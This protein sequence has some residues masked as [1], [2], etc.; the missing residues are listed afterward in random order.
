MPLFSKICTCRLKCQVHV[1]DV[2]GLGLSDDVDPLV[3]LL[4]ALS[5]HEQ[6]SPGASLMRA[7]GLLMPGEYA[8]DEINPDFSHMKLPVYILWRGGDGPIFDFGVCP[9]WGT[10]GPMVLGKSKAHQQSYDAWD[11]FWDHYRRAH[12]SG[13]FRGMRVCAGNICGPVITRK[14]WVERLRALA[15]LNGVDFD[16][17]P[18]LV[19][20]VRTV[21]DARPAEDWALVPDAPAPARAAPAPA[22]A[23]PAPAPTAAPPAPST[24]STTIGWQPLVENNK[25]ARGARRSSTAV[26]SIGW[27]PLVENNKHPRGWCSASI[28]G[29]DAA[30]DRQSIVQGY[31][32]QRRCASARFLDDDDDGGD[33][34]TLIKGYKHHRRCASSRVLDDDGVFGRWTLVKGYKHQR[35]CASARVLDDEDDFRPFIEDHDDP[36]RPILAVAFLWRQSRGFAYG[37]RSTR[38]IPLDESRITRAS[39]LGEHSDSTV[40][41]IESTDPDDDRSA[42]VNSRPPSPPIVV[43]VVLRGLEPGV[44]YTRA[45]YEAGLGQHAE[46][47]GRLFTDE[48]AAMVWFV[49]NES[50]QRQFR[51]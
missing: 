45:A 47:Y 51:N 33:R 6:I 44:H 48:G 3:A 19:A 50:K 38:A 20:A 32:R 26:L 49:D 27:Q 7:S 13:R 10:V 1:V 8:E 23:A 5:I 11:T 22:R 12:I 40:S 31:K 24:T 2:T 25:H 15:E 42:A 39:P 30:V 36:R 35:R 16:S 17:T 43:W 18:E 14:I 41:T 4:Q 34:R 21:M 28:L 37:S 29:L 46:R 9:D